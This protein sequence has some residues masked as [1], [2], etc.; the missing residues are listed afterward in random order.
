[1]KFKALIFITSLGLFAAKGAD[2]VLFD[3]DNAPNHTPLPITLTNG[4]IT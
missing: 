4:G 2:S 3:F 1:M